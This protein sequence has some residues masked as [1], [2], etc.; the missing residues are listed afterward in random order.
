MCKQ[1]YAVSNVTHTSLAHNATSTVMWYRRVVH[2][3]SRIYLHDTLILFDWLVGFFVCAFALGCF[4]LLLLLRFGG[5]SVFFL[6]TCAE[7]GSAEREG[8]SC[9]VCYHAM[10]LV[11]KTVVDQL[12]WSEE[13]NGSE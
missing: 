10:H 7:S 9:C 13:M 5:W 11:E 4:L 2:L 3:C 1:I 6:E 12:P 8:L